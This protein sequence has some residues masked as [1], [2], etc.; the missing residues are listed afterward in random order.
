VPGFRWGALATAVFAA[1]DPVEYGVMD[2]RAP[3]GAVTAARDSGGSLRAVTDREI[4]PPTV[5][6]SAGAFCELASAASVA[7]LL[8]LA[9]TG[10]C[11]P[12]LQ[13]SASSRGT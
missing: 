4:S 2:R 6:S 11:R 1:F 10:S 5:S 9:A 7:G 3:G 12:A 8:A 13:S